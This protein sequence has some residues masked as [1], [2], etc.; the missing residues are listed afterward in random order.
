MIDIM[1]YC[2]LMILLS[3]I[4]ELYCSVISVPVK[5]LV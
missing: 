5:V 2:M 1:T 4:A 3:D